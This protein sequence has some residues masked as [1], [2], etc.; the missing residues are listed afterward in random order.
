MHTALSFIAGFVLGVAAC[1]ALAWWL[2]HGRR[3]W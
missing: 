1:F 2:E 3:A